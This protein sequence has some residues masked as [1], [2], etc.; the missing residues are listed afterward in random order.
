MKALTITWL[1]ILTII[2]GF[3]LITNH[4]QNEVLKGHQEILTVNVENISSIISVADMQDVI[5]D[6]VITILETQA[7]SVDLLIELIS[8]SL[9]APSFNADEPDENN[10]PIYI[11][12]SVLRETQLLKDEG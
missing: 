3:S 1:S 5:N 11:H 2:L 10:I 8:S 7:K 4:Y 9:L 6:N 12:N